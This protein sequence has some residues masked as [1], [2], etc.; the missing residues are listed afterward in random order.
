M[1]CDDCGNDIPE[2]VKWFTRKSRH[3][4]NVDMLCE[5]CFKKSA[6]EYYFVRDAL[7]KIGC[8]TPIIGGI[9]TVILF[10]NKQW[11]NALIV[12]GLTTIITVISMVSLEK[13]VRKA[14]QASM[15]ERKNFDT[16][17]KN[18]DCSK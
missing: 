9:L 15:A 6:G 13:Y 11:Q 18:I 5:D 12:I 17:P 8:F 1:Y 7:S 4:G 16:K 3:G 2:E 14:T 10:I